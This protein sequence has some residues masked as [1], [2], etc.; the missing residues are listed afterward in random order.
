MDVEGHE[1]A[2]IQ[3]AER[4]FT[5]GN[6]PLVVYAEVFQ[7]GANKAPF[8]AKLKEWG[9]VTKNGMDDNDALLM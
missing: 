3:G 8:F 2:V 5:T 7:L 1:Y 6:R 4:F 9:Y